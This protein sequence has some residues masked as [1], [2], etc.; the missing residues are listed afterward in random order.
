MIL[1]VICKIC[2]KALTF[3]SDLLL[4]IYTRGSDLEC[5]KYF[6][7]EVFITAL[8]VRSEN[9]ELG[10]SLTVLWLRL[11]ASHAEDSGSILGLGL[12][13]HGLCDVA[14]IILLKKKRKQGGKLDA[15]HYRINYRG[16]II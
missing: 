13:S 7:I 15:H 14:K 3:N 5:G 6:A 16:M 10:T 8:A 12:R 1:L 4:R 9:K 2:T 11:P